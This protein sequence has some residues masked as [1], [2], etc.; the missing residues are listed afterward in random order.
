MA[1]IK[2]A[3]A[4]IIGKAGPEVMLQ[5]LL[6]NEALLREHLPKAPV[7]GGL[8]FGEGNPLV[9]KAQNL[10]RIAER[11]DDFLYVVARAISAEETWGPNNNGDAFPREEL[12]AGHPTF[13]GV[14]HFVD[15]ATDRTEAVRGIVLDS[16]WHPPVAVPDGLEIG[17]ADIDKGDYVSVLLAIDRKNFPTYAD[18][19]ERGVANK[20]SMGVR[21]G[22]SQ[23]SICGNWAQSEADF[24]EHIP[25]F[26][27]MY[28]DGRH[29]F[30]RNAAL[31]FIEFSNVSVP[32]DP[33]AMM[34]CKVASAVG[35]KAPCT[36]ACACGS[37]KP[38]HE[39]FSRI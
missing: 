15:H 34:W 37:A 21:V 11:K 30:E 25:A 31:T 19:V 18:Q 13:R 38:W 8:R 27:A 33:D 36:G 10:K 20:F 26:K 24:C 17:N 28:V 5:A 7:N 3:E 6:A 32:A 29:C 14:G 35:G 39:G 9:E 2:T 22:R 12:V 16:N 1:F 23:C 4:K